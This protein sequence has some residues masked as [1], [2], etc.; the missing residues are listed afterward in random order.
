MSKYHRQMPGPRIDVY[1]VLVGFGVTCP[2]RA[3]AIKKLL[4]TGQ[5]GHK[6]E[7][8]DLREAGQAI[9]RAIGLLDH[10]ANKDAR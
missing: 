5:R 3:H 8:Q 6:D 9:N 7:E 2:A 10:P 1:D 4:A